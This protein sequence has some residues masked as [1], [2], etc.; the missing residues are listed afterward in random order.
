[1]PE[2]LYTTHPNI[3]DAL[4]SDWDYDRDTDFVEEVVNACD[5]TGTELLEVG[6]GTGEHTRRFVN[7]GFDVTAVD[8]YD[9]MLDRA[10]TKCD[11]EFYQQA[12]PDLDIGG[13]YDVIVAIRGVLNHLAPEDLSPA[14][15]ALADSLGERGVLVFDN[16]PL[17]TDGNHPAIDVGTTEQGDYGRIAQHIPTG[18]GRLEWRAITMTTDGDFFVNSRLMTPFDDDTITDALVERG[19]SVETVDG[20]GQGDHRTVFVACQ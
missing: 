8:K 5:V 16:S 20:Y 11:A 19:F 2:R 10:R 1:M 3:Y 13:T 17:P 4:Q 15:D 14:L 6:C 18:D 9:G 7:A 12:L